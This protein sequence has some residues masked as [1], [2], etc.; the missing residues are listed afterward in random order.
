M[1]RK[2]VFGITARRRLERRKCRNKNSRRD[3][4]NGLTSWRQR[5]FRF[6]RVIEFQ[7]VNPGG[8]ELLLVRTSSGQ[9]YDRA[10]LNATFSPSDKFQEARIE[11]KKM[12]YLYNDGDL[13]YFMD[14]DTYD[15]ITMVSKSAAWC[16]QV[17]KENED[18]QNRFLLRKLFAVE[19]ANVCY[20]W[21]NNTEPGVES[22][23]RRAQREIGNAWKQAHRLTSRFSLITQVSKKIDTRTSEYIERSVTNK[24][25]ITHEREKRISLRWQLR[26]KNAQMSRDSWP[27]LRDHLANPYTKVI[28]EII[29]CIGRYIQGKLDGARCWETMHV[30]DDY[31][32]A[33]DEAL[34]DVEEIIYDVE[35]DD[36]ED[37]D[38]EDEEDISTLAC[39]ACG[40]A[41]ARYWGGVDESS[42]DDAAKD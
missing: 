38:D 41:I 1:H 27:V 3:F 7:H 15:Q 25:T 26:K 16:I 22:G 40:K 20:T 24:K 6:Y 28:N 23:Q 17:R 13:Y 9:C 36:D 10:L 5:R 39:P 31:V 4:T 2:G 34:G 29:G 37:F 21:G 33:L 30:L 35:Y 14:I 11:R 42:A 32:E 19:A 8:G 18:V 12:Q